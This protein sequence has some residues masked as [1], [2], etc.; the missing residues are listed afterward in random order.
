MDTNSLN[1]ILFFGII[2]II[3]IIIV[4]LFIFNKNKISSQKKENKTNSKLCLPKYTPYCSTSKYGCC[5]DGESIS[6]DPYQVSCQFK[7][8]NNQGS[9]H[10]TISNH[11]LYHYKQKVFN[12]ICSEE[13]NI[14]SEEYNSVDCRK[15]PYGCCPNGLIPRQDL[16]GSNCYREDCYLS[17]YGCC[18]DKYTSKKD[19]EGTNCFD[20]NFK[21]SCLDTLYGCCDD[22]NTTKLDHLGT[23]C[24]QEPPK[25]KPKRKP[26][27][28][29]LE[30]KTK[31]I[32][33]K[34]FQ[35][36]IKYKYY[37]CNNK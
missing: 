16:L 29:C 14:I 25:K 19:S 30:R 2:F 4:I 7:A 9:K 24:P 17:K 21:C 36:D 5:P 18:N 3:I 20:Y 28:K 27:K 32:C 6:S 11:N 13:F 15:S 31:K 23:N 22:K 35:S 33:P 12:P 34:L 37:Q 10:P 8:T 1:P 26:I